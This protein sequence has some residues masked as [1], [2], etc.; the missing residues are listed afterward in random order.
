MF[1]LAIIIVVDGLWGPQMGPMNLA[2]VL[3]WTHWRGLSVIALLAVGNVICMACP[4]SFARDMGRRLLSTRWAPRW[5]SGWS[6][7]RRL[8]SKWIAIS[9]L[10]IFFW[11]YEA[12][13]L[14][15]NPRWTAWVVLGSVLVIIFMGILVGAR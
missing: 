11:G 5:A 9:L 14:W 12:F 10:L 13:G 8:R 3:P 7:P 1:L 4:F 2:G 6:W 15:D